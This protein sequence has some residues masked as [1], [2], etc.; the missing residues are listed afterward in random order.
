MTRI[1]LLEQVAGK[2]RD[3]CTYKAFR[4]AQTSEAITF[5]TG[6]AAGFEW[7]HGVITRPDLSELERLLE[8]KEDSDL[9]FSELDR[10]LRIVKKYEH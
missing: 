5:F 1:D 4:Q 3:Q 7:M 6:M 10:Q 8:S 2:M 9:Q